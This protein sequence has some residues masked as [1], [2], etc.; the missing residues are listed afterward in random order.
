MSIKLT[1]K[2]REATQIINNLDPEKF[3]LFLDRV[4]T[5]LKS[6]KKRIVSE[7]ELEKLQSIFNLSPIEAQTLVKAC[8]FF[9]EQFALLKTK[10][11]EQEMTALEVQEPHS[12]AFARTWEEGGSEFVMHLKDKLVSVPVMLDTFEWKSQI[13]L[14]SGKLS[15][16]LPQATLNLK[17]S[18]ETTHQV[19]FTREEIHKFYMNLELIQSQLDNLS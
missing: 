7:K 17:L 14:G 1:S 6:P 5:G 15:D 12:K 18:D 4:L 11:V 19:Q 3:E 13:P 10:S 2:L 9:F 8:A 16:P